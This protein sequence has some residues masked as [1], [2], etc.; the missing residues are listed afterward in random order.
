MKAEKTESKNR[1][2]IEAIGDGS[3]EIEIV[4][5]QLADLEDK[6]DEKKEDSSADKQKKQ[7][8][9]LSASKRSIQSVIIGLSVGPVLVLGLILTLS[10]IRIL[11]TSIENELAETLDVA[12]NSLYN[13]Y[14]LVAPGNYEMRAD[15]LYKG[16]ALLTGNY[17]II[18]AL[19][20][21]YDLDMSLCFGDTRVLTTI[22]DDS[23]NRIV[24][25]TED[26]RTIYWVLERNR[27]Y[28]TKDLM[29]AGRPYY[30][31][32]IPVLNS[33][34]GVVGMIFAGKPASEV[35]EIT[36]TAI[37]K[38][39][40]ISAVAT[41][42]TLLFCITASSHIISALHAIRK[43]LSALAKGSFEMQL[44]VTVSQRKDEIGDMGRDAVEVSLALEKKVTTDPLTGLLNRRACNEKLAKMMEIVQ[45]DKKAQITVC[46]GDI[47]FFKSVNDTYGHECGDIV[48][49]KI[50]EFLLNGMKENGIVARWGGEEFL[51]VFPGHVD[52]IL[53]PLNEILWQIRS[54][55]FE[56]EDFEP[57]NVT[58]SIGVNGR[59]WNKSLDEVIK[60][61]DSALYEG[62]ENGRNRIV[63]TDGRVLLP[64]GTFSDVE[65]QRALFSK[66]K[67]GN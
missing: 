61:A 29:I 19:K 28:F 34:G 8:E 48:L 11:N 59:I 14:S 12:A 3:E 45:R 31:Y 2:E 51:M 33:G 23:G 37:M 27:K 66:H 7:E 26:E 41:L 44:P 52:D 54:Y 40:V 57:F 50:S 10:M 36:K 4:E 21:S 32:Y 56:Y 53:Q 30:G 35:H 42:F 65:E 38:A 58:M 13:T 25:T 20:K 24:G 22:E 6:P 1:E 64:D 55:K 62:K 46:I 39:G 16:D 9:T 67:E 15:R 43:Y 63:V 49:K 5:L 47:D 18:D 17:E 60:E